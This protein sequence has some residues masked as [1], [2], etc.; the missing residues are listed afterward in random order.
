MRGLV[1][2][3]S[4]NQ[5]AITSIASAEAQERL[6]RTTNPAGEAIDALNILTKALARIYDPD[7]VIRALV[8]V[9]YEAFGSIDAD[10]FD[11]WLQSQRLVGRTSLKALSKCSPG[12][13]P[14]GAP[15]SIPYSG[16]IPPGVVT[17]S[18]SNGD[19][20]LTHSSRHLVVTGHGAAIANAPLTDA[21]IDKYC[22][23]KRT[24]SV[25]AASGPSRS[26]IATIK[27]FKWLIYQQS[28]T[29]LYCDPKDCAPEDSEKG[30]TSMI[31]ADPDLVA[32]TSGGVEK[33]RP[34]GPYLIH[35]QSLKE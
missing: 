7:S 4:L 27:C 11:T 29:V 16:L 28:W 15:E 17:L 33:S 8:S 30:V 25:D 2:I 31:A 26:L 10:A 3:S 21:A 12:A 32:D 35:V 1:K 20:I 19:P 5:K 6:S 9:D 13:A 22:N 14:Q 23:R 24:F 18:V 34:I